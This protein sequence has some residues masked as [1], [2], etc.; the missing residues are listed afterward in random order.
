MQTFN[1][2]KIKIPFYSCANFGNLWVNIF[3][4]G[5]CNGKI[6]VQRPQSSKALFFPC[7]LWMNYVI[8]NTH[9]FLLISF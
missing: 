3:K 5:S 7:Y 9:V 2:E 8:L 4:T 6:I 1:F